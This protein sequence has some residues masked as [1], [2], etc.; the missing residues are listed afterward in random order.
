[1]LNRINA[2]SD[3]LYTLKE[4]DYLIH[5]GRISHLSGLIASMLN[6]KPLIG[7]EKENGT[8]VQ[9]GRTRT[10][11]RAL[12]AL[13]DLIARQHAPGSAL[14]VQVMHADNP[15][16]AESLRA[17]IDQHFACTWLPTQAIS[18][19]LGA[20]TGPSLT[21]VAYAPLAAFADLP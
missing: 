6:I 3:S 2:A 11:K 14:R 20:H 5:G 19:V 16:G 7:V 17:E 9:M 8:Y 18:L 13:V 15:E 4:L 12:S 10:F 1:M 21:A